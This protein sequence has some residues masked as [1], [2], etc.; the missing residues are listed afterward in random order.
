MWADIG[1]EVTLDTVL[2]IPYGNV[3]GNAALLKC[4]GARRGL[5]I[6]VLLDNGYWDLVAF[7]AIHR[8][9]DIVYKIHNILPVARCNLG[10]ALILGILPA[11][12]NFNLHNARCAGIDGI[13]VHLYDLVALLAIRCLSGSL[14]QLDGALFRNDG[15]Q[16]EECG[17][18]HGV[19]TPA[20]ADFLTDL[21]TVNGIEFNIVLSN[22]PL[23]LAWQ[24]LLQLFLAPGAVEEEFAARH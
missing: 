13:V 9:L 16:F 3:Y 10:K 6:F 14:H 7:L 1:A 4:C 18:Q 20:K 22:I 2:W 24:M 17:L 19:D 11:V 23:Y 5:S 12:W 15:S 21:D 8:N